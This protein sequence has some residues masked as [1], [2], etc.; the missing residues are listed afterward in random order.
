MYMSMLIIHSYRKLS[1]YP[2]SGCKF[3]LKEMYVILCRLII[4][5]M[6]CLEII[7]IRENVIET[8]RW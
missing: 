4:I 7:W 1:I 3:L 5:L 6:I 2:S 8:A